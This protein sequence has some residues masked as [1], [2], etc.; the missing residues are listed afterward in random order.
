MVFYKQPQY[1]TSNFGLGL[2]VLSLVEKKKKECYCYQALYELF[3]NEIK[4]NDYDRSR[5]KE[6]SVAVGRRPRSIIFVIC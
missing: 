3:T 5:S 4:E 6:R 2:S 1:N